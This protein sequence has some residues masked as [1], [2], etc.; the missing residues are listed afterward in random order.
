[1]KADAVPQAAQWLR[2]TGCW[3]WHRVQ[4]VTGMPVG[5]VVVKVFLLSG[6]LPRVRRGRESDWV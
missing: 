6:V 5:V 2:V 3:W 4:S 1:M